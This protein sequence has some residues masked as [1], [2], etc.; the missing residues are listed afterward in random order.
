MTLFAFLYVFTGN[1]FAPVFQVLGEV[2]VT[3]LGQTAVVSPD[4]FYISDEDTAVER[5]RLY[6]METARNGELVKSQW[7]EDRTLGVEDTFTLRDLRE[8][9]IMFK[10][11]PGRTPQGNQSKVDRQSIKLIAHFHVSLWM[12]LFLTIINMYM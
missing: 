6:V 1:Q 10:H 7:G 5:L 2:G 4:L 8:K 11:Y 9:R 3:G 12:F